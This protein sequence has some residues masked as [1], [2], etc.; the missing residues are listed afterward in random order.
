ML[1]MYLVKL[2]DLNTFL[3][4]LLPVYILLVFVCVF[5]FLV[6][7]CAFPM[8]FDDSKFIVFYLNP[9]IDITKLWLRSFKLHQGFLLKF[10]D[11]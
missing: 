10:A 6:C 3:S 8:D 5:I 7:I 11:L 1:S 2:K 9:L 4:C